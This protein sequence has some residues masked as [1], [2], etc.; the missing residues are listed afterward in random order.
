VGYIEYAKFYD[1]NE[2]VHKIKVKNDTGA[3]FSSIDF[4][5]AKLLGFDQTIQDFNDFEEQYNFDSLKDGKKIKLIAQR[6]FEDH[7]EI[8]DIALVKQS[9]GLDLRPIVKVKFEMSG[10]KQES[11]FTLT[12]RKD[13]VYDGIIGRRGLKKFLVDPGQK[14]LG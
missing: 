6:K 3:L 1:Q 14:F 10:V 13:L 12:H 5:L 2:N 8:I 4:K 9:T 11:K 7:P